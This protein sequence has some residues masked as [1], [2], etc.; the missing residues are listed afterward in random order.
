MVILG[1]R[2][3]QVGP[4]LTRNDERE[5][6]EDEPPPVDIK[7]DEGFTAITP[8]NTGAHPRRSRAALS[9]FIILSLL[10]LIYSTYLMTSKR[11]W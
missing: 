1:P 5:N 11:S 2:D 3:G 9:Y 6:D 8:Y 7:H 4:D 10:S